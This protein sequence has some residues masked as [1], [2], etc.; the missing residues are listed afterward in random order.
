MKKSVLATTVVLVLLLAGYIGLWVYSAQWFTREIDR[1]YA[2]AADDGVVYLGP[3][4]V[5]SNFPFVPQVVYTQGIQV[6][7]ASILFPEM[8]LRGYPLP[9]ATL[10]ATFPAGISLAG[11]ADP[12]IWALDQLEADIVVPYKLPA[13][14][15]YEDLEAWHARNGKLELKNYKLTKESL[16]SEGK[17]SLTLDDE[18]QPV[19]SLVSTIKGH[20]AF[21]A[22]QQEKGLIEPLPAAIATSILNGL[23]KSDEKTGEKTV[24]LNVNVNDRMLS[25]GPLQ[26][27]E[28]PEILWD[29]RTPP[30]QP[31]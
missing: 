9:F 21:I 6:G 2:N 22:A 8:H 18:L 5:L 17:G 28:L 15:E 23:S 20:D 16:V 19:F 24:T 4:P 3:K 31:Q 26:V 29:R 11:I 14:F 25:V 7:N 13:T 12:S 1:L 27:L 30:D 10:K